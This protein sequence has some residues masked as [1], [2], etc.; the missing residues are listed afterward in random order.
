MRKIQTQDVEISG[1]I[2]FDSLLGEA[3][4]TGIS[5]E[6]EFLAQNNDFCQQIGISNIEKFNTII[7]RAAVLK[8]RPRLTEGKE[9]KKLRP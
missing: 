9:F 1:E 8:N 5:E 2:L 3:D 4:S 7:S 6:E